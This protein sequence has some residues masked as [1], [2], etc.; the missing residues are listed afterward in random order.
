MPR[1]YERGVCEDVEVVRSRSVLAPIL[2]DT[3]ALVLFAVIGL[4]SHDRGITWQGLLR[5]AVP[6]L[7]GW[8]AA[9]ALFHV[10][11][12]PRWRAFAAAWLVGITAGVEVRGLVLHRHVLGARYLTFLLVTLIVTLVLLFLRRA[13]THRVARSRAMN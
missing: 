3:V 6:V 12:R 10:Y 4:A 13:I 8:F 5:D 1:L 9:A 11:G 2:G 7:G